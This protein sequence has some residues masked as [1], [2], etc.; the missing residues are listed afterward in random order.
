MLLFQA[1]KKNKRTDLTR[2]ERSFV[3][4]ARSLI[5]LCTSVCVSEKHMSGRK[6]NTTT[7]RLNLKLAVVEVHVQSTLDEI[8]QGL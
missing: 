2:F 7:G 3:Q 5:A 4:F 1:Q 8:K 6:E